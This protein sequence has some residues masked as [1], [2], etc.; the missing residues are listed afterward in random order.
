MAKRE[1]IMQQ[2]AKGFE[3]KD[4]PGYYELQVQVAVQFDGLG[5]QVIDFKDG[6]NFARITV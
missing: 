3:F 1:N 6:A 2:T 4:E 5:Y